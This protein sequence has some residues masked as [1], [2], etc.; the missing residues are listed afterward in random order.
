MHVVMKSKSVSIFKITSEIKAVQCNKCT[1]IT[2][3][4]KFII[5]ISNV[6]D[7]LKESFLNGYFLICRVLIFPLQYSIL[8]L[9]YKILLL[10]LKPNL[11][12]HH[13]KI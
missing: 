6:S 11:R 13:Y 3:T 1:N 10:E 9:K 5:W 12:R 8:S 7:H 2:T 4:L